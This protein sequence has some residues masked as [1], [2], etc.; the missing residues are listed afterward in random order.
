MAEERELRRFD[1]EADRRNRR[2]FVA[3]LVG[4]AIL[5]VAGGIFAAWLILKNSPEPPD[6]P[7]MQRGPAKSP[8]P[9]EPI[10]PIVEDDDDPPVVVEKKT[11]SLKQKPTDQDIN[12][13]LAKLQ[14][15]F[16]QCA[17]EHG[18]LEGTK[19]RVDFSVGA[20]GRPTQSFARNPYAR[21]PLGRCVAAVIKDKGKFTRSRDGLADIRREI[22]LHPGPSG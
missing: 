12:R 22:I 21:T 3:L 14:K 20:D 5:A 13:G 2:F 10:R 15:Y 9:I 18:G 19:V 11:P 4:F 16:N 8:E 1:L 17:R 7:P 6:I